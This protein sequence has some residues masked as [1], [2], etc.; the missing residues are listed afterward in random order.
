VYLW[1]ARCYIVHARVA[2]HIFLEIHN[3]IAAD[4]H[5]LII[6]M[7][8]ERQSTRRRSTD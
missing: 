4:E 7:G 5:S 1:P 6:F 3:T 8:S 2:S